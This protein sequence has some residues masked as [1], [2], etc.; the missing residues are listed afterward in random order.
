MISFSG[1]ATDVRGRPAAGERVHAGT[2]TSCTKGTSIRGRRRHGVKSGTFTIPTRGHDFSGNT[3]YRITLTV[4]DSSGLRTTRSVIVWPTK[5]NLTFTSQSPGGRTIYLDGIAKTTPFVH[6]TLVGF[7]HTIQART[8][9]A[10]GKTYTFASWS[11]GGAQQHEI[12]VPATA[13]TFTATFTATTAP[14]RRSSS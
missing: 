3:R 13:R 14:R 8:R 6:D 1:D 12:V 9:S 10:G 11:D 5:V 7:H 4:V 2:S